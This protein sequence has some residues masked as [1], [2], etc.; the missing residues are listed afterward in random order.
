MKCCSFKRKDLNHHYKKMSERYYMLNELHSEL[1]RQI[2]STRRNLANITLGEIHQMALFER[3]CQKSHLQ[4][5]CKLDKYSCP[6][7]KKKHFLP[8]DGR[9]NCRFRYFGKK[10]RRGVRK[11]NRCFICKKK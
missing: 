2:A 11:T 6:T 1:Q 9:K 7:K 10:Q 5:K 8:K 3:V 4:I